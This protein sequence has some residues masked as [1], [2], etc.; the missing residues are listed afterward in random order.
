MLLVPHIALAPHPI[1]IPCRGEQARHQV[2]YILLFNDDGPEIT[3]T[4]P[5]FGI[6]STHKK[7]R[8]IFAT[9]KLTHDH[10]VFHG[11]YLI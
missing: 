4:A 2:F 6:H 9:I 3:H 11:T 5:T 1:P 8:C 7:K 10:I